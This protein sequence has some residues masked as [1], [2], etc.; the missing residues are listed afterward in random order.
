MS[1]HSP[2]EAR[3]KKLSDRVLKEGLDALWIT[4][5]VN[6]R[7][8][9][10]FTG[11]YAQLLVT[12]GAVYFFTDGRYR[13]QVEHEVEG[14]GIRIFVGTTWLE[15]FAEEVVDHDWSRIGFEAAHLNVSLFDQIKK[16]KTKD[17][18]VQWLP[19]AGW[20]EELRL[21][22]DDWEKEILK[23]SS[24]VV[25]QVF[26]AILKEL[27]VGITETEVLRK[28]MNLFWEMGATGPS[29]D[30]II[31]FGARS[32]LPHGKPGSQP[33]SEG[34]WVLLDFGVMVDGYCSDCTRTFV[35]GEPDALQMERH[36][37]VR[38]AHRMGLAAARVGIAGR[39]A[40]AAARQ[41]IEAAGFGEAF[42]HGLGH[43]V[44]LEIHEAPRLAPSSKDILQS[45]VAVT[46]EPGVY[47]PG[48][49]GIR[50]EDAV[51]V[52]DLSAEPL[53]FCSHSI[54]PF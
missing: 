20:V 5:L 31:L 4:N 14:C 40:D 27:R 26:E 53:T 19:A 9:T 22:K 54:S 34:N 21:I 41:V 50:I 16:F 18:A 8:L 3:R 44:G 51:I 17:G 6:I 43:G 33:L 32:S 13:E 28:M 46:I 25:D 35:F 1:E 7:Y 23:R 49:G 12:P 39:D 2:H 45:G 10:G 29:F 37:L 15:V 47:I 48:W 24:R 36:A 38:E 42:M 30:P 52:G 11:T